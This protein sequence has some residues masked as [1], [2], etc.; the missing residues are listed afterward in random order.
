RICEELSPAT[1]FVAMG[2]D[3]QFAAEAAPHDFDL[4]SGVDCIL[5]VG[6]SPTMEL[7]VFVDGARGA[8][9]CD[10]ELAYGG[11]VGQRNFKRFIFLTM[12]PTFSAG[13]FIA[14]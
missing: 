4:V 11:V 13:E 9:S 2:D 10:F 5:V 3:A 1:N 8:W 12:A 6:C 7:M 14:L